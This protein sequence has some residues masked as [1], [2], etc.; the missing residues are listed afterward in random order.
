M[1]LLTVSALTNFCCPRSQKAM[2]RHRRVDMDSVSSCQQCLRLRGTIANLEKDATHLRDGLREA[3]E[4]ERSLRKELEIL[5]M[6][7]HLL[8]EN[9]AI[10][11]NIAQ[12]TIENGDLA[13]EN[14]KLRKESDALA[15]AGRSQQQQFQLLALQHESLVRQMAAADDAL[16]TARSSLQAR[17]DEDDEAVSHIDQLVSSLQQARAD[18][19]LSE[20]Q[21]Q[22]AVD[23]VR[24]A[25]AKSEE[26]T[27]EL[28][29]RTGA[30]AGMRA[31]LTE[32]RHR[33]TTLLAQLNEMKSTLQRALHEGKI[34]E[35]SAREAQDRLR[36]TELELRAATERAGHLARDVTALRAAEAEA[37]EA[38]HERNE[39]R[40]CAVRSA[41][42]LKGKDSEIDSLRLQLRES[43]AQRAGLIQKVSELDC[44][45]KRCKDDF[46]E[47]ER[48]LLEAV[49]ASRS[50][51]LRFKAQ[52]DAL[53]LEAT[54][55]QQE[56]ARVQLLADH[57][58]RL[59]RG[60]RSA[61]VEGASKR[62]RPATLSA[63][64][65]VQSPPMPTPLGTSER[66]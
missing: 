48:S 62:L 18:A 33:E 7:E 45:L 58:L 3:R 56:A 50:E 15:E 6:A 46:S 63:D 31:A 21:R 42:A 22:C 36:P 2:Q 24:D 9:G 1:H 43:V 17:Q 55:W 59:S 53:Q 47:A 29:L 19:L 32:A 10:V 54:R 12:L 37:I 28:Q 44:E 65:M 38:T 8:S 64:E 23:Q 41:A 5:R 60:I 26:V 49:D 51:G 39:L 66:H 52:I 13:E 35:D 30:L 20:Q 4:V 57:H 61:A 16:F 40:A 27:V 11:A 25:V 34:Q 14:G